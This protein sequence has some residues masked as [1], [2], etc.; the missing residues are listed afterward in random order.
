MVVIKITAKGPKRKNAAP[1][2]GT[3]L[4]ILEFDVWLSGGFGLLRG[5][6]AALAFF[7]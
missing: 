5:G 4:E 7:A 6:I 3:A 2:L 1:V